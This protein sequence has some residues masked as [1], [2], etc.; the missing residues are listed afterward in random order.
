MYLRICYYRIIFCLKFHLS[1]HILKNSILYTELHSIIRSFIYQEMI[2]DKFKHYDAIPNLLR[3]IA[4]S[5][6]LQIQAE[7]TCLILCGYLKVSLSLSPSFKVMMCTLHL[8]AHVR[9]LDPSK[10]MWPTQSISTLCLLLLFPLSI[11]HFLLAITAEVD[12]LSVDCNPVQS[13]HLT[14]LIFP[15][16]FSHATKTLGYLL[17]SEDLQKI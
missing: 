3:I 9:H 5:G 2:R 16:L 4:L 1:F 6:I 11:S 8:I 7:M 12:F 10:I 15:Y 17:D 13:P 14:P